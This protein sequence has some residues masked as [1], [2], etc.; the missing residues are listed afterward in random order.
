MNGPYNTQHNF[1]Q[2]FNRN[3]CYEWFGMPFSHRKFEGLWLPYERLYGLYCALY[4]PRT[5]E[6]MTEYTLNWMAST[7]MWW[8]EKENMHNREIHEKFHPTT[9]NIFLCVHKF[10]LFSWI[11][12]SNGW[13]WVEGGP[14]MKYNRRPMAKNFIYRYLLF[15]MSQHQRILRVRNCTISSCS[16]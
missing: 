15:Q 6:R 13:N 12:K 2:R 11:W 16:N 1:Y 8:N 3:D 5:L 10:N 9:E 14:R 4:M 7:K